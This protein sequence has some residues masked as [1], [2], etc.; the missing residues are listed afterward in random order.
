MLEIKNLSFRIAGKSIFS[1]AST[2]IPT[3]SKVGVVGRNGTGKTTL[4][5]LIENEYSPDSGVINVKKN[6]IVSGVSQYVPEG[7]ETLMSV[8]LKADLELTSLL[9][10]EKIARNPDRISE[11]QERL[12]HIDGY[13]AEARA[14]SILRGL[15][16][17]KLDEQRS[18][19]EFSGGW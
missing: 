16:F 8:V 11:I 4:F 5:K 6:S 1:S 14:S 19:S 12:F 10:E 7:P 18:C 13:S 3:G 2:Y 9:E 15:G 17:S